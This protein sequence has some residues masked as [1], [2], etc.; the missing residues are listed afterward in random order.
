MSNVSSADADW[1]SFL[2]KITAALEMWSEGG[3]GG[4]REGKFSITSGEKLYSQI[5]H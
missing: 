3:M 1:I 5:S 4:E 2:W